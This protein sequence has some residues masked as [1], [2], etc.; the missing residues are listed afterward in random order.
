MWRLYQN[1]NY[2]EECVCSFRL[3]ISPTELHL[4]PY[5]ILDF[6]F[7]NKLCYFIIFI[8]YPLKLIDYVF[9]LYFFVR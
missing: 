9:K 8:N 4:A 2:V 3:W 6:E 1:K 7:V 5:Y